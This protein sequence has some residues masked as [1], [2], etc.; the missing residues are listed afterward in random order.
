MTADGPD[1]NELGA[2]DVVSGIRDGTFTAAEVTRACLARIDA[3]DGEVRAWVHLDPDHALDQATTADQWQRAGSTLGPL[4]GVPIGIKDIFDTSDYLTEWG[5]PIC[6]GRQPTRDSTVVARLR[7]AGAVILGKTVTAEFAAWRPGPTRNPHDLTRTPGGSSSG[8]A[9][10]VA[11]AMVPVAVG[12]QTEGSTIR[13]AS[14]C[15]VVGFKPTYGTVPLDGVMP[16]SS[17][18]DHVGLFARS[19]DDIA[20]AAQGLLPAA[21]D[22]SSASLESAP[23][24]GFVRTPF[25]DQATP[26]LR[27][28]L[29]A[30][31]AICDLPSVELP[32]QFEDALDVVDCIY[33]AGNAAAFADLYRTAADRIYDRHRAD[34]ERGQRITSD[35]LAR[36]EDKQQALIGSLD[37]L[38]SEF[39]A[40]ATPATTGVAGSAD[41]TGEPLFNGMWTLC[42][43]PVVTLPL[44][45][46]ESGLPIGVQLVGRRGDD[47]ELFRVAAHI[48]DSF[49]I[50]RI[51]G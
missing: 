42:G 24:V 19:V 20:L 37:G 47:G 6:A 30:F 12:S 18:L 14:Y 7:D 21:A 17:P 13:P 32:D 22:L 50:T 38:L 33:C 39:D 9:A 43:N 2:A 34:I 49:D 35:Q 36:A 4:H 29:E 46:G 11:D 27:R 44:L 40:L 10:A 23:R 48:T 8:S 5:S 28:S 15:G 1:L 26:E 41:T 31:A 51:S 3:R 16:L 45:T 25:W